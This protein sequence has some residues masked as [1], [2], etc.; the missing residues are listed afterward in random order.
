MDKASV[1][2]AFAALPVI[3]Y[4]VIAWGKRYWHK[5][6]SAWAKGEGLRLLEFR[7]AKFFEGPNGV[8]R[9]QYQSAFRVRVCDRSGRV[10]HAWVVM[11]NNW[12]PFSA[13]D[14][15]INVVWD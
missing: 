7:G 14:E 5:R 3:A 13:P 12:N 8:L 11:G 1:L 9:T 10:K 15:L 6:L 2:I 4:L